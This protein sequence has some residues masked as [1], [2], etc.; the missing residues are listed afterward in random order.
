LLAVPTASKDLAGYP[1]VKVMKTHG[2]CCHRGNAC[3]HCVD[4]LFL[5]AVPTSH[6]SSQLL[7]A[8]G[9]PPAPRPALPMT[10]CALVKQSLDLPAQKI[11]GDFAEPI[12]DGLNENV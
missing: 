11:R 10:I 12:N 5:S 2:K 8:S 7:A 3:G 1:Q 9:F 6:A 4:N